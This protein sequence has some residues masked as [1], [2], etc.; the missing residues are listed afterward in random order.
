[1]ANHN[2]WKARLARHAK[3]TP[4]SIDELRRQA[5]GVLMIA[6]EDVATTDPDAR[7]KA[8]LAFWQGAGV[9]KGIVEVGEIEARL[10]A[11]EETLA[12][13]RIEQ[14]DHRNGNTTSYR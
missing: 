7:R 2:P 9:Y 10:S 1:M 11:I 14:A 13:E 8:I 3:R 6:L 5:W 4:G 12:H